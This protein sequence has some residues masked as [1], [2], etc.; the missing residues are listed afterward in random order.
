[1]DR[2]VWVFGALGGS[3]YPYEPAVARSELRWARRVLA[4]SDQR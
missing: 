4:V 2:L 1:M 3:V